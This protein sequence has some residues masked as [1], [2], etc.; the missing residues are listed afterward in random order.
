MGIMNTLRLNERE[1]SAAEKK[2]HKQ[3]LTEQ[4]AAE[5]VIGFE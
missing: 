2:K 4:N 3:K 5:G 1:K